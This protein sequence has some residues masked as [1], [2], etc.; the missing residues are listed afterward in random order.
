MC[1]VTIAAIAGTVIAAG[2]AAYGVSESQDARQDAKKAQ[3]EQEAQQL[4]MQKQYADQSQ[5]DNSQQVAQQARERQRILAASAGGRDSTI[6][7]SPIGLT[8]P[9]PVAG[10]KLLGA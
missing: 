2:S 8:T 6:Q 1:V 5:Q 10:K 4:T 7:T 3:K 9:A